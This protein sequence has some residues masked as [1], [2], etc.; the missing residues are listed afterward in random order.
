MTSQLGSLVQR[1]PPVSEEG[2]GRGTLMSDSHYCQAFT[3]STPRIHPFPPYRSQLMANKA[4]TM[5]GWASQLFPAPEGY[6]GKMQGTAGVEADRT[7]V[8]ERKWGEKTKQGGA[9]KVMSPI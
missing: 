4:P 6:S 8:H 9:E 1:C 5:W 3:T 7:I 2:N